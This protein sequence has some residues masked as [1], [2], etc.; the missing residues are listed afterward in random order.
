MTRIKKRPYETLYIYEIEGHVPQPKVLFDKDF[1]GCWYEDA[2]SFL[3]FSASQVKT[4]QQAIASRPDLTYRSETVLDYKNWETGREF[5]P[6]QISRFFIYPYWEK[7]EIPSDLIAIK[8]DP[9]VVFGSGCHPTTVK[10]LES[11]C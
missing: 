8:I 10:C 9:G 2:Y 1:I 7:P 3:F 11:L 6:F 5:T 4:V